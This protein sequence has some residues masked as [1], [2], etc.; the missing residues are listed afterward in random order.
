M[1]LDNKKHKILI[2]GLGLMGG[3]YAKA[4]TKGGF[5]VYA[6]SKAK[7]DI[8][9]ALSLGIIKDGSTEV[10]DDFL[11][12]ADLIVFALYPNVMIEWIKTNASRLKEG[13]FIT[14]VCGVKSGVIDAV[15]RLLPNTVEFISAHPMAG[16]ELS[17]IQH[18]DESVF[19]GANYLVVPDKDNTD[20]GIELCSSLAQV[21]G[22][23]KI[24]VLSA[25]EHDEMIAFL[26]QLTHVIA[27]SLMC[28]N[29]NEGLDKYTGDSFRDLT[30]IAKINEVMWSELFMLNK[31]A[32]LSTMQ[33]FEKSFNEFKNALINDDRETMK[34][35]MIEST[36]KRKR[37]DK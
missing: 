33:D 17:G 19:K 25:K 9:Y 26:S 7:E 31:D 3:S 20:S 28:A 36:A 34:R 30:R 22:F 27:V 5:E 23:G 37:F 8:D 10:K 2:V 6:I 24:S 12:K 18:S 4:L 14:D 29:N 32:L 21:L 1:I 11:Q 35:M 16:R 13:T 15:K